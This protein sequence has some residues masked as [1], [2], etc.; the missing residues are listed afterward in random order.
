M[1]LKPQ[2]TKKG[3]NLKKYQFY[4]SELVKINLEI[5]SHKSNNN[6]FKLINALG[7]KEFI[8]IQLSELIKES[9]QLEYTNLSNKLF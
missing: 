5:E 9:E 1:K 7:Q 8:N 3:L 2:K 6:Q 4:K